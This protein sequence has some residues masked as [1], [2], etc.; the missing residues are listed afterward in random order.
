MNKLFSDIYQEKSR[1]KSGFAVVALIFC[2]ASLYYTHLLV[3]KLAER[4][5][6]IIDLYAKALTFVIRS[7]ID[8][9]LTF[10]L[11]EIIGAN[12]SIPVILVQNDSIISYRNIDTPERAPLAYMEQRLAK[13]LAL[14]KQQNPPIAVEIDDDTVSY[15]YYRNSNLLSQ[16]RYYPYIQFMVLGTLGFLI[17]I[18]FSYSRRAEQNRVWVGLA[19]ETAHQLGTPISSLMAWIDYMR[20]DP[21]YD[22]EEIMMELEKDV[23]RLQVVTARFSNIGSE[24]TIKPE[25][26]YFILLGIVNYLQR[27][28]SSKVTIRI[29]NHL[30]RH[31][32]VKMN[33]HLFEWVIENICKNAVDA[34]ESQGDILIIMS[35]S[36][37]DRVLIDISD[38]GK[39]IAKKDIKRVFS[40]G[41]TTKKRGWGLGLT[42]AKRIIEEYHR[43]QIFIKNSEI[44]KGTTFRIV[45]NP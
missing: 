20:V 39:G 3:Q 13:E 16:L 34:M 24:P 7:D 14:M 36:P 21:H 5:Q 42:L 33:R 15:I 41:F 31:V 8:E 28:V 10:L 40:P 37:E 2:V 9:E 23:R 25:D 43:G 12:S 30:E 4:E 19:K 18:A 6:R 29:E 45:L 17:Y 35:R 38:T 11:Q 27:R 1:F 26:V 32:R 22:Q 44:D